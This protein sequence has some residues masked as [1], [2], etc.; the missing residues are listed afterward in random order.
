M[1]TPLIPYPPVDLAGDA[2]V[3]AVVTLVMAALFV[4]ALGYAF[5]SLARTGR[6]V[7]LLMLIGGGCMMLMEPMVDT[8]AG[9][10]FASSSRMFLHGWGRSIPL[11]VCLTYFVYFGV[12]SAI[13]WQLMEKGITARQ[14]WMIYLGEIAAD[15][16]LETI[17][18]G[19]GIYT[20]YGDQPLLMGRFPFW[21]AAVNAL[22]SLS[23]A[24]AVRQIAGRWEGWR[25]IGIVPVMLCA[26][27]GANA[28]AGWPAWF[29]INSGLGPMW[30]Q[31]GGVASVAIALSCVALIAGR[32]ATGSKAATSASPSTRRLEIA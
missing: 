11:W 9:V 17:V 12:G 5:Y 6:P 19:T 16:L 27:A 23:S 30:T 14:I 20:Y 2:H 24:F 22:I 8:T 10:W 7:V 4:C 25:Q 15:V 21:W 3:D 29:V 1:A 26:S 28:A 31:I 13:L 32:V 18:L